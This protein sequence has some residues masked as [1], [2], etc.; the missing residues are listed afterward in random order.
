MSSLHACDFR[1]RNGLRRL[2]QT[3]GY[4]IFIDVVD[5]VAI[6]H[7][8]IGAWCAAMCN[9]ITEARGWLSGINNEAE[10]RKAKVGCSLTEPSGLPPL[11]VVGDCVIFYLPRLTMTRGAD[12][13]TIFD[14]LLNLVRIPKEV[15]RGVQPELH[16]AICLCQDAYE[17]TFVKGVDDIHGKDVDLTARLL[18]EAGP[19]EI[20]MNEEFYLEARCVFLNWREAGNVRR[21]DDGYEQ[22]ANVQ[23]PWTK[24]F[25]GFK[26]P[27]DIYKWHGPRLLPRPRRRAQPTPST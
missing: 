25:R 18:K 27:V 16:V 6:K 19:Q 23:G 15:R 3:P 14:G 9:V 26:A 10:E 20:V 11:K 5:S 4:C 24:S 7:K 1:L 12:A 17:V 22:F 8:G 13:L 21:P 2:K